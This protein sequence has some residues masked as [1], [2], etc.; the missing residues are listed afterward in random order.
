LDIVQWL[1]ER[2]IVIPGAGA[3]IDRAPHHDVHAGLAE[4]RA[5]EVRVALEHLGI[6]GS[7]TN[8]LAPRLI[9]QYEEDMKEPE[10]PEDNPY[11]VHLEPYEQMRIVAGGLM[12]NHHPMAS[13]RELVR[14]ATAV[15]AL[16]NTYPEVPRPGASD[17]CTILRQLHSQ[18]SFR[19]ESMEE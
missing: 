2:D 4:D 12:D 13:R 18:L 14:M 7:L 10:D 11:F 17:P 15:R 5:E 8:R 9:Q 3:A 16:E 6:G 1:A 19:I